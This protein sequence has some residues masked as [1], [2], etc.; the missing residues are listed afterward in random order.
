MAEIS[1]ICWPSDTFADR[2]TLDSL[3]STAADSIR[4]AIC[5]FVAVEKMNTLNGQNW[6]KIAFHHHY[7]ALIFQR[8]NLTSLHNCADQRKSKEGNLI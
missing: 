3:Y 2:H 1:S 4:F 8:Q 5:D 6:P 7:F